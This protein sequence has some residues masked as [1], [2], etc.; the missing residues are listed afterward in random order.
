MAKKK[1]NNQKKLAKIALIVVMVVAGFWLQS[2]LVVILGDL[3]AT[4]FSDFNMNP[5]AEELKKALADC[6]VKNP[7]EIKVIANISG[8][9][10]KDADTVRHGLVKQLVQPILWQKCVEKLLEEGVENFY[11]IGPGR[12]L[13]GLMKRINRRTKVINI[14]TAELLQK[15]LDSVD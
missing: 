13:T 3:Q 5:A 7:M 8:E 10:Y 14:S 4:V 15:F 11:E 9:Y 12:V 1:K 6:P 2:K